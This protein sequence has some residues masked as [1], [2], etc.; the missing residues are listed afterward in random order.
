MINNED[1]ISKTIIRNVITDIIREI[2]KC[3]NDSIQD[4]VNEMFDKWGC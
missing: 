3:P 4:I 2:D 1:L